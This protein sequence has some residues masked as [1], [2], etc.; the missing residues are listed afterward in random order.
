M[1]RDKILMFLKIIVQG[2]SMPKLFV[3]VVREH[4]GDKK[5]SGREHVSKSPKILLSREGNFGLAL[6]LIGCFKDFRS[7]ANSK[8]ICRNEGFQGLETKYIG[9]LWVLFE[10]DDK[11]VEGVPLSA[12]SNDNFKKICSRWGEVLFIDD[13]DSTNRFSI[14]LCLKSS[15]ALLIFASIV[16]MFKGVS[17]VVRLREL[18]SWTPNFVLDDMDN[19]EEGSVGT[20]K[21]NDEGDSLEDC[22][23]E[24]V[25]DISI[26]KNEGDQQNREE[27]QQDV[28]ATSEKET[29]MVRVDMWT[30]RQASKMSK[31]DHFLVNEGVHDSFPY[32]IGTVLEKGVPDH[33]PIL[34]KESMVDC[35]PILFCFFHLWL[36]VDGFHELV[37]DIWK[38]CDSMEKHQYRFSSVDTKVDQ[39]TATSEDL[40]T[41]VSSMKILSY[42]DKKEASDLSQKAKIKWSIEGDENTSFFHRVLKKK[43]RQIA[44]KG[45]LKNGG[46]IED[47]GEVKFEFYDHFSNRLA[48]TCGPRPFIG[49]LSFN[50]LSLEQR[51]SLECDFL[52]EEIKRVVWDCG[53][54]RAPV[55]RSPTAEFEIFKRLQ[56][57][58]PMSSFLFILDLEGLHAFIRKAVN[59]G[60]FKG[61][62]IGQDM[63]K[64]L[65]CGV[66]KLPMM[67]LGVPVGGKMGRYGKVGQDVK[68]LERKLVWGSAF[69]RLIPRVY[70][71]ERDKR[72][73]VAQRINSSDWSNVLRRL[74]RGCIESNQFSALLDATRDVLLSDQEDGSK[75]ALNPTGFT[76]ASARKHIDEH[77]LIG[78]FTTT[79]WPKCVPI[80]VNVFMWRMSLDKLVTFVNMYRKDACQVTKKARLILEGIAALM[81]W[82]IWKFRNDLL[83]GV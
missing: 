34:L 19:K 36:D 3:N 57:G 72:C 69:K 66:S 79:R 30:L 65:G 39:G 13:T 26:N 4:N 71:L 37:V 32:I 49:E 74:P 47:P 81:L 41:Q 35:G 24:S 11:E 16:V 82:S 62:S 77:I 45:V 2:D 38:N 40:N 9:G 7:I 18:C 68:I 27:E 25:G 75:W 60:V 80:K 52:N 33:R 67:Y 78:G 54:E 6:A 10:F 51:D 61:V 43:W 76:V 17:Y 59:V 20:H 42:I 64:F 48:C 56:Q 1:K 22:E 8:I 83:F 55:N 15:H 53:G 23:E 58:D 63:A 5:D 50:R 46:W 44:I 29:K 12:L 70:A 14:R 28:N 21:N 31:L 73:T